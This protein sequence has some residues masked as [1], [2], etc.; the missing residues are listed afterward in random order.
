[1]LHLASLPSTGPSSTSTLLKIPRGSPPRR[2]STLLV[3][4]AFRVSRSSNSATCFLKPV[5]KGIILVIGTRPTGDPSYLFLVAV[6]HALSMCHYLPRSHRASSP[7]SNQPSASHPLSRRFSKGRRQCHTRTEPSFSP[8]SIHSQYSPSN[9]HLIPIPFTNVNT[10]YNAPCSYPF[11]RQLRV[12]NDNNPVVTPTDISIAPPPL[13]LRRPL[14]YA[15]Y[16]CQ[17]SFEMNIAHT[18]VLCSVGST[19]IFFPGELLVHI[20]YSPE[21][22]TFM[23]P[24]VRKSSLVECQMSDLLD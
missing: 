14:T 1:M 4:R 11:T 7:P 12:R 5:D 13:C 24:T 8:Q 3:E 9:R 23:A 20:F 10:P 19:A 18:S 15:F 22:V 16:S 6:F 2:R 17:C 21:N